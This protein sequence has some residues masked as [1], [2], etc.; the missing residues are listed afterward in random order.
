[1]PS[2]IGLQAPMPNLLIPEQ[3]AFGGQRL[4]P[5]EVPPRIEKKHRPIGPRDSPPPFNMHG[6][7]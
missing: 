6:G 5:S 3:A 4:P 2:N 7:Q 1:M